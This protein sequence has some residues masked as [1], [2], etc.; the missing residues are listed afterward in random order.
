MTGG[1]GND[2]YFVDN[3]G[4]AVIESAGNGTD[5]V[6]TMISYGLTAEVEN[7]TCRA[8]PTCGLRQHPGQH[9]HRQCRR[10]SAGRR[11]RA[12]TMTGGAGGDTYS[13]ISRRHGGRECR[14]GQRC[15]ILD[16]PLGLTANVE[17]LVLQGSADRRAMATA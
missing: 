4:D 9:D 17:T 16:G 8:A 3:A 5:T 7:L 2:T 10:Q 14:R 11:G 12:D 15:G 1:S 13:S 6:N